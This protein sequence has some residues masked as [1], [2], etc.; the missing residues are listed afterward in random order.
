MR[1]LSGSL[2]ERDSGHVVV[3][4]QGDLGHEAPTQGRRA[5]IRRFFHAKPLPRRFRTIVWIGLLVVILVEMLAVT[6]QLEGSDPEGLNELF[7][8][9]LLVLLVSVHVQSG[10]L[11]TFVVAMLA[12]PYW[13]QGPLSLGMAVIAIM[14]A[15]TVSRGFGVLCAVLYLIW[16][17]TSTVAMDEHLIVSL[18][19]DLIV[20]AG[21]AVGLVLRHQATRFE[22]IE[23]DL[24]EQERLRQQTVEAER[25]QIAAELHD[26]VA[27]GLTII[28][29]QSSLLEMELSQQERTDAQRAIGTAAR[30]SLLDLRRM[31]SVL[32]G[33]DRAYGLDDEE[34]TAS[35]NRRIQD[36]L[37]RLGEAG[38]TVDAEIAD[39]DHQPRSIQLTLVR[40]AQEAT[41]N[42]L[43]HGDL[44]RPVIFSLCDDGGICFTVRNAVPRTAREDPLPDSG[45]GLVG[46]RERV[47]LFGGTLTCGPDGGDWVV[48]A[49][50]P[51]GR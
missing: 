11:A 50:F 40:I 32:H 49:V 41:T 46:M 38:V 22:Q 24:A 29:M 47:E 8:V 7:G 37:Q 3:T 5:A 34:M 1:E 27:H 14:V 23:A 36:I 45:F 12:I 6:L 25:R 20:A 19:T 35:A 2:P 31:L 51:R 43:K 39:V 10:A 44:D 28:A 48:Q 42:I 9:S 17:I 33:S 26:V 15:R 16:T 4:P 21:V 13:S 18:A 30:Q